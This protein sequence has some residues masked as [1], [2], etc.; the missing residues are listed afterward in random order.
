MAVTISIE[1]CED[2]TSGIL[3]GVCLNLERFRVVGHS[4]DWFFSEFLF[5]SVK[6]VLAGISPEELVIFFQQIIH[7]VG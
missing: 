2:C 1:L 3:G 4:E 6:G 5:Q 7:R